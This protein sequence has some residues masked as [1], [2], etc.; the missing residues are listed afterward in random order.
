MRWVNPVTNLL[1]QLSTVKEAPKGRSP[2]PAKEPTAFATAETIATVDPRLE[3]AASLR[4]PTGQRQEA[5]LTDPGEHSR[6]TAGRS[7]AQRDPLVRDWGDP[8][9]GE[10]RD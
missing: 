6:L 5:A 8:N 4:Q 7:A 9:R 1:G 2:S 10:E 3:V